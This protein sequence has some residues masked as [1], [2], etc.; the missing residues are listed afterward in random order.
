MVQEILGKHFSLDL[1]LTVQQTIYE[2]LSS[3]CDKNAS[4]IRRMGSLLFVALEQFL[5]CF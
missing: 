3:K 5:C 2:R 4:E 1:G